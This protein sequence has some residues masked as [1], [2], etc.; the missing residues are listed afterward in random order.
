MKKF[1][2]FLEQ[3]PKDQIIKKEK[4]RNLKGGFWGSF[5]YRGGGRCKL[6]AEDNLDH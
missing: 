6:C 2:S 1:Q 3:L 5:I 4:Q